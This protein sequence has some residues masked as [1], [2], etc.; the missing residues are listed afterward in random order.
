MIEAKTFERT[1]DTFDQVLAVQR[2]FRVGAIG[3]APVELGRDG[4]GL[5]VKAHATKDFAH[6][7]FGLA[8]G[9]CL[10]IVKEGD[11]TVPRGLH[12]FGGFVDIKLI[13]KGDP[14]TK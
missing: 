11:T 8:P 2:V 10:G 12:A 5:A 14:A 9:V 4:V 6:N 3:D 7:D 13:T 1:V